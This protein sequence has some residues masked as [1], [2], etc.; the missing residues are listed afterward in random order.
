M[1]L[2]PLLRRSSQASH[3]PWTHCAICIW[4]RTASTPRRL[5]AIALLSCLTVAFCRHHCAKD[6]RQDCYPKLNGL[7]PL[8]D[9][10]SHSKSFDSTASPVHTSEL[11]R[12]VK[13]L[14]ERLEATAKEHATIQNWLLAQLV[15]QNGVKSAAIPDVSA[16]DSRLDACLK[17]MGELEKEVEARRKAQEARQNDQ[18]F[19]TFEDGENLD[20]EFWALA[21][22]LPIGPVESDFG[23]SEEGAEVPLEEVMGEENKT[24]EE[25]GLQLSH[26]SN[27]NF[28][29]YQEEVDLESEIFTSPFVP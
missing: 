26:V 3:E 20:A 29:I 6:V 27:P 7:L 11:C 14:E 9:D 12:H 18:D 1:A 21:S 10:F 8:L 28:M 13:D 4:P 22:F 19:M 23:E 15:A 5:S 2:E 25:P 24:P 17:R 16:G